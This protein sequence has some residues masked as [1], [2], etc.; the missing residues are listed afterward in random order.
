M[1]SLFQLSGHPNL[2]ASWETYVIEQIAAILPN[3][4]GLYFY[5]TH[6]GT[7]ADLVITREGQAEILIEIKYSTTPKPSKGFYIA[8]ADLDTSKHFIIS[9]VSTPFPIKKDLW[10]LGINDLERIFE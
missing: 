2:G 10:V 1:G 3:W 4:A 9:P 5:R 7:E 8:Q 6:Q